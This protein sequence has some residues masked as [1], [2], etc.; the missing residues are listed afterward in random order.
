[1]ATG[2][3]GGLWLGAIM[4]FSA[5]LPGCSSTA[6]PS[7]PSSQS[8]A[9]SPSASAVSSSPTFAAIQPGALAAGRYATTAFE[10]QLEFTVEDGWRAL[11]ADDSDELAL[12]GE[13]GDIFSITRPTQVI[14]PVSGRAVE[15]PEDLVAWLATHP[16]LESQAPEPIEVDGLSGQSIDTTPT[17]SDVPVFAYEAGK[18]ALPF[19]PARP[20]PRPRARRSRPRHH[21][22]FARGGLRHRRHAW[23]ADHRFVGD[24]FVLSPSDQI[25]IGLS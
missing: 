22:R 21:R 20:V 3:L 9:T 14:D 19:G 11:F 23:T 5:L 8:S 7:T 12:E 15:T 1:M 18:H 10:P 6:S 25:G 13:Q 17:A 4:A 16:S 24:R 2:R